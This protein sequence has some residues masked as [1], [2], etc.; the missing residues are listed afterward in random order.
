MMTLVSGVL[1]LR[2]LR[3]EH[4]TLGMLVDRL[5]AYA[6]LRQVIVLN[7]YNFPFTHDCTQAYVSNAFNVIETEELNRLRCRQLF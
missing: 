2:S 5:N 3:G 1:P 4:T 6:A 7:G